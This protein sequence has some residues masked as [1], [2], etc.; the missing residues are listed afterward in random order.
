MRKRSFYTAVRTCVRGAL[1]GEQAMHSA[2]TG[3]VV[4]KTAGF[5]ALIPAPR[6]P[7]AEIKRKPAQF[8]LAVDVKPVTRESRA[9]RLTHRRAVAL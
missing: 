2:A 4:F 3:P 6:P 1:V 7:L 9:G 8:R 5:A